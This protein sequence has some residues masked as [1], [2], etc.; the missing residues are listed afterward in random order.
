MT[1]GYYASVLLA[2]LPFLLRACEHP[3]HLFKIKKTDKR[4]GFPGQL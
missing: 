1:G 4:F 2:W 3:G